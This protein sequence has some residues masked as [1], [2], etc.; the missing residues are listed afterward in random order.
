MVYQYD[1]HIHKQRS[2]T[3][4]NEIPDLQPEVEPQHAIYAQAVEDLITGLC[5][6]DA[7]LVLETKRF[8]CSG[9]YEMDVNLGEYLCER[10]E[11]E[12][13]DAVSVIRRF[14]WGNKPYNIV[15]PDKHSPKVL[16]LL[17]RAQYWKKLSFAK[18][19]KSGLYILKYRKGVYSLGKKAEV[20]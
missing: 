7:H 6:H 3:P 9:S 18:D 5:T 19:Y 1:T 15:D 8:L 17:I 16:K 4:M 12:Y 2:Y 14:A 11:A 10:A 13:Q 20:V